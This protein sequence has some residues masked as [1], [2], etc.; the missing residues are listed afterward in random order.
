VST[1]DAEHCACLVC[2]EESFWASFVHT[3]V[4]H[5]IE[6]AVGNNVTR[7]GMLKGIDGMKLDG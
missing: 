3:R 1:D 4:D 5:S 2:G 7:D 6:M